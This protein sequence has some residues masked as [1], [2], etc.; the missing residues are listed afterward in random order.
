M[1]SAKKSILSMVGGVMAAGILGGSVVSADESD[2]ET[3]LEAADNTISP[4]Y[5]PVDGGGHTW[6]YVKTT[7]TSTGYIKLYSDTD[8][9]WYY[10]KEVYY[11]KSGKTIK[12]VYDKFAL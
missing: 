11:D 6:T 3:V 1:T 9:Y 7:Y 10:T 8:A 5:V 4:L 12:T 2:K